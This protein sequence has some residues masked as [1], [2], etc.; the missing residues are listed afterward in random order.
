V[1]DGA[2]RDLAEIEEL[3][4]PVFAAGVVPTPPIRDGGGGETGTSIVCGGIAVSPGD[5]LVGDDD[6][7]VVVPRDE[8]D[9]LVTRA[10]ELD[11]VE[12]R[13]PPPQKK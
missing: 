5:L 1:I 4:F 8:V 3:R 12:R 11:A 2:V 6:G 9:E 7:V 10:R 13:W